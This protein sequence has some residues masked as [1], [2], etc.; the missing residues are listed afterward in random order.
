VGYSAVT[1][2]TIRRRVEGMLSWHLPLGDEPPGDPVRSLTM[3]Y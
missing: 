1:G 2:K 3:P